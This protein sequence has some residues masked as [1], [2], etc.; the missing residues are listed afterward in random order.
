MSRSLTIVDTG[1]SNLASLLAAFRRLDCDCIASAE[2]KEIKAAPLLLLPGVGSFAAGMA[3]LRECELIEPLQGRLRAGR[4]TL[5]ICLGMQLLCAG[6]EESPGVAGLGALPARISRF[7]KEQITPH[8]GW[9][10]VTPDPPAAESGLLTAGSAYFANSFR[11]TAA[12]AGWAC[13]HTDYGDR[14]VSAIWRG[15]VLGCQFHPELSGRWGADLLAR[16]LDRA[17]ESEVMRGA[18]AC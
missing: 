10:Q 9:N 15:A 13:A 8:M 4:P 12:P 1:T 5:G 7:P 14:F 18:T 2:A 3:R 11:L 6:S 16:W 17:L